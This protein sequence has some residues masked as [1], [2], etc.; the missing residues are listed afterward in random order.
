MTVSF[1]FLDT[2]CQ[3]E[4]DASEIVRQF[5]R[6]LSCFTESQIVLFKHTKICMEHLPLDCLFKFFYTY[7]SK[8]LKMLFYTY[9]A[10]KSKDNSTT[11]FSIGQYMFNQCITNVISTNWAEL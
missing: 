2:H 1:N 11:T 8:P 9:R 6:P 5:V 7:W 3:L 10:L 4:I